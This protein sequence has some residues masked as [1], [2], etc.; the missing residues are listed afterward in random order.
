MKPALV[1]YATS[2]TRTAGTAVENSKILHVFLRE[3]LA[4]LRADRDQLREELRDI[5]S[6][7]KYRSH[8]DASWM[9][10]VDRLRADSDQWQAAKDRLEEEKA[11]L[12][13]AI[14]QLTRAYT[15]ATSVSQ[16][17]EE[18]RILKVD[19]AAALEREREMK[20]QIQSI[21]K[22]VGQANRVVAAFDARK[23]KPNVA[24]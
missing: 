4:A 21:S 18:I 15:D 5:Q 14:S 11:Q 12:Q 24:K 2:P 19:L 23:E 3:L 16:K 17:G 22:S 1:I 8:S 9:R 7:A 13:E 6:N 20:V 10:Q